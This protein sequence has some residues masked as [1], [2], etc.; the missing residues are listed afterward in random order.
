MGEFFLPPHVSF[1]ETFFRGKDNF[2]LERKKKF[3]FRAQALSGA[4]VALIMGKNGEKMDF[5]YGKTFLEKV[6]WGG[7]ETPFCGISGPIPA[8]GGVYTEKWTKF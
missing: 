3:F 1:H 8:C 4:V 6:S 5:G 7:P 2:Q